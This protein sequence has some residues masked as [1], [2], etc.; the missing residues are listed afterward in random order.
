MKRSVL[1]GSFAFCL[2][3]LVALS[4]FG[5]CSEKEVPVVVDEDEISKY[6]SQV[7]IAKELFRT[8]GLI[9]ET[10][11]SVP[12]DSAIITDRVLSNTRSIEVHLVPL[13]IVNYYGDTVENA[14]EHVYVDHGYLG[15]LRESLVQVKDLMAVETKFAY[16]K[17]TLFDTNEVTLNR[18][19][20]FLKMGTDARDYAGWILWGFNGLGKKTR[21]GVTLKGSGGVHFR[22][23]LG[24]YD[25]EPVSDSGHIPH[26]HYRR[27]TNMDT[28]ALGS[29]LLVSTEWASYDSTP[30]YQLASDY[31]VDGSFTRPMY[32]YDTANFVDSLSYQTPA[33]DP[34]LYNE[35]M[36]QSIDSLT[37]PRRRLFVVPYRR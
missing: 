17:D 25:E 33:S 22:G 12:F 1:I 2:L 7:G 11:Y 4:F 19:G 30:T 21:V 34:R 20:F 18:Y 5:G 8:T 10:P 13:K 35:L 14:R 6:I 32:R 24:L 16:S 3:G 29:R 36:I 37:F 27:L 9:N 26:I 23:D 15:Q 31:D 28:V